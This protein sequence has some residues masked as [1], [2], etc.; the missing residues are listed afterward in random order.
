[1]MNSIFERW[2]QSLVAEHV[3]YHVLN[4]FSSMCAFVSM[5]ETR[6]KS[7]NSNFSTVFCTFALKLKLTLSQHVCIR[8]HVRASRNSQNTSVSNVFVQICIEASTH[9]ESAR[10]HLCHFQSPPRN[11]KNLL[12]IHKLILSHFMKALLRTLEA[13]HPC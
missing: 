7:E 8:V 3:H 12:Q 9:V 5:S 1:M 10:V 4:L 11:R 13:D 2:W 6:G